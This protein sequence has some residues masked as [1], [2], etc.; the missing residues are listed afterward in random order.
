[1]GVL[2][3]KTKLLIVGIAS[4]SLVLAF[5]V[6]QY[7]VSSQTNHNPLRVDVETD[8]TTYLPGELVT[9]H[10]SI[11]NK[12]NTAIPLPVDATVQDGNLRVFISKESLPFKE[13]LG[14]GWGT[15][16]RAPSK[17]TT[18]NPGQA[19]GTD[20]TILWNQT[21][22]TS[23]LNPAYAQQQGSERLSNAYAL[24]K[25]GTYDI[26]VVLRD[27]TTRENLESIPVQLTVAEPQG[28]D[29][30][31]WEEIRDDA[32]YG[33]FMQSGGL[34]ESPEEQKTIRIA[35]SLENLLSRHPN[36]KYAPVMRSGLAKRQ[37]GL[38]RPSQDDFEN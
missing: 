10:I 2:T 15:R 37:R 20:A 19:F 24:G 22:E 29:R 27:P 8:K 30:D 5:C 1:M 36:S 11:V 17:P 26:K 6:A 32:N 3:M 34:L 13:Y 7:S 12:S 31:V 35:L 21:I 28:E 4:V 9:L 38:Q 23:H 18:L 33:L 16:D 14:P 25:P